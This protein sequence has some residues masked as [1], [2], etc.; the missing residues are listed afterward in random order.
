MALTVARRALVA[1][2][3]ILDRREAIGSRAVRLTTSDTDHKL[4]L[5]LDTPRE[6][7]VVLSLDDATVMIVEPRLN[8]RLDGLTFDFNMTSDGPVWTLTRKT[9]RA[10]RREPR[11]K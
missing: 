11:S 8:S 7:D 3:N 9:P 1:L 2:R 10:Q 4:T 5:V 6:D